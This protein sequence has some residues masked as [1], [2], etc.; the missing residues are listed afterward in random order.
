MTQ[1]Y[2]CLRRRRSRVGYRF[3]NFTLR[4]LS[5]LMKFLEST[6]TMPLKSHCV[7]LRS[8]YF[9]YFMTR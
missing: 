7:P 1:T 5:F 9:I 8:I 6:A 2:Y 4:K 3:L